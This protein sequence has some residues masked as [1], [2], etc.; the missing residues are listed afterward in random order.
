MAA[1][2]TEGERLTHQNR[3]QRR[4]CNQRTGNELSVMNNLRKSHS[5]TARD[6]KSG[7]S[8]ATNGSE[9]SIESCDGISSKRTADRD[10]RSMVEGKVFVSMA[11]RQYNGSVLASSY[12]NIHSR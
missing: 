11:R 3:M 8:A 1:A 6:G 5:A 10:D 7:G 12:I 2:S 9:Q 4:R